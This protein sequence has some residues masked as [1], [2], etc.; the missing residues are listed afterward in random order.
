MLQESSEG[1]TTD[2][3]GVPSAIAAGEAPES[4]DSPPGPAVPTNPPAA[5]WG[6][7][8]LLTS[9]ENLIPPINSGAPVAAVPSEP[10]TK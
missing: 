3:A 1:N 9:L 10:T 7:G 4:I 2:I 5:N 6:N 8:V